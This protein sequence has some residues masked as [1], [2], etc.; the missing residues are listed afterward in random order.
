[1]N[2]PF[3]PVGVIDASRGFST[4]GRDVNMIGVASRRVMVWGD[5]RVLRALIGRS[6][7]NSLPTTFDV[8]SLSN[9]TF[10]DPRL[11]GRRP[12][13]RKNGTD[14]FKNWG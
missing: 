6:G 11:K 1:M 14:P 9:A 3:A 2:P 5:A 7:G 8:I 10:K 12:E 13:C 4:H